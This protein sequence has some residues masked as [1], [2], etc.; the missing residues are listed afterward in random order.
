MKRIVCD[1][2]PLLHLGEAG[3]RDLLAVIPGCDPAEVTRFGESFRARINC[4]AV[5]TSEGPI[6]ITLSLGVAALEN[7]PD[8]KAETLVRIA[9]AALYRAKVAGRNCV[10]LAT[11]QDIEREVSRNLQEDHEPMPDDILADLPTLH[12]LI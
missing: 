1:T 9:D 11:A 10:A 5:E 12:P 6:P 3:V 7:L 2:G 4:K 8:V